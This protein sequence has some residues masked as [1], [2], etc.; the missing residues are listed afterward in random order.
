MCVC[1]RV[2]VCVLPLC[3]ERDAQK[4]VP[5]PYLAWLKAKYRY[6]YIVAFTWAYCE[7]AAALFLKMHAV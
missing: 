5:G 3:K 6:S 2:C 1:V 4:G 7:T